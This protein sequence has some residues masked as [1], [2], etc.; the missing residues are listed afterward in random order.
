MKLLVYRSEILSVYV[1]VNLS[2]GEIGVPEHLLN[3]AKVG[4]TLQQMGGKA[5]TQ[6]MRGN[7]LGDAGFFG[8][9]LDDTPGSDSGEW[10]ASGVEENPA[11][12]SSP[13]QLG[14]H[15]VQIDRDRPNRAP[16]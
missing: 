6:G 3:R 12:T 13:I 2:G 11:S 8:R 1:G 4:T 9:T 10:L 7:C 5:V 14:A 15:R 16:A